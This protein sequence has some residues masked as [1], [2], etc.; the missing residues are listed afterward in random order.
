LLS[1]TVSRPTH[2]SSFAMNGSTHI[3]AGDA[4][5]CCGAAFTVV[6]K[7]LTIR[8]AYVRSPYELDD[9]CTFLIDRCLSR[10]H[11]VSCSRYHESLFFTQEH[12][13]HL[14][15]QSPTRPFPLLVTHFCCRSRFQTLTRIMG[16][17][18]QACAKLPFHKELE[19]DRTTR[20]NCYSHLSP[21]GCFDSPNN[22]TPRLQR[23][24]L[25]GVPQQTDFS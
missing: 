14:I 20:K 25:L 18:E 3:F 10:N 13:H 9:R 2:A 16:Q 22:V 1:D 23:L 24:Y 12:W 7:S 11:G 6:E 17:A 4:A 8:E 15:F 5:H 19:L 21:D